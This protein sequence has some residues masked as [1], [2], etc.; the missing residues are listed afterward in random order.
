[1]TPLQIGILLHYA[2]F[3]TDYRDGDFTAPTVKD[4][5][6]E[7]IEKGLLKKNYDSQY[8]A[9]YVATEGCRVYVDKLCQVPL[10]EYRWGYPP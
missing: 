8:C 1:M 4:A 2:C 5:M 6:D 3:V 10:P 7:F 9:C